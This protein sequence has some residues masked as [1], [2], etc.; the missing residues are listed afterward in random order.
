MS[1][2]ASGVWWLTRIRGRPFISSGNTDT[3]FVALLSKDAHGM[4]TRSRRLHCSFTGG[5]HDR[6]K[7]V[8]MGCGKHGKTIERELRG[9]SGL[10]AAPLRTH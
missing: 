2:N 1:K 6:P 5:F 10:I 4:N 9:I 3:F 8:L 7:L